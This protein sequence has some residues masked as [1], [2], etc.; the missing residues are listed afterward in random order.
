[1]KNYLKA[2]HNYANI[3]GRMA[4]HEFWQF[5]LLNFVFYLL[6]GFITPLSLNFISSLY[7]IRLV[8]PTLG[9][10]V[11]RLHD[12]GKSGKSVVLLFGMTAFSLLMTIATASNANVGYN[13]Y[14]N[15]TLLFLLMSL[16]SIGALVYVLSVA[17]ETGS[18][19]YGPDPVE[20][21]TDVGEGEG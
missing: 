18:N 7:Q 20:V 11:R 9:A 3:K 14:V 21:K 10:M 19:K 2:L 4:R 17:G 6:I 13:K 5:M 12:T 15:V 1:M 8:S 16:S